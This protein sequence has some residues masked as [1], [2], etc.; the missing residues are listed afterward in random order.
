M[1]HC[2]ILLDANVMIECFRIGAWAE[3]ARGC[4]LESVEECCKE[5]L[6]GDNSMAG[7]VAVDATAL[8]Q[9]LRQVH[10]VGRA[11][12]NQLILQHRAMVSL[13]PGEMDLYAHLLAVGGPRAGLLVVSTA[14]KGAIVRA[15]DLGWLDQLISFEE[16]LTQAGASRPKMNALQKHYGAAW[17]GEVRTKIR[18]GVIP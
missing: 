13:D 11:E 17:L 12:R 1:T 16:L 18:L 7:R 9:G 3:L 15:N 6:T 4:W 8:R 10:Q 14:D 2:R 5:A